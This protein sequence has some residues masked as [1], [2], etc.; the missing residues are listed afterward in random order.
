M[1]TA[2]EMI[3]YIQP[4]TTVAREAGTAWVDTSRTAVVRRM[5]ASKAEATQVVEEAREIA[6]A[7]GGSVA[8][9]KLARAIPGARRPAGIKAMQGAEVI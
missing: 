9:K 1:T 7:L 2:A 5:V 4:T 8:I 6:R 3:C